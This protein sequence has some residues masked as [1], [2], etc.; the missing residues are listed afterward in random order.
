MSESFQVSWGMPVRV[1]TGA[2]LTS[3]AGPPARNDDPAPCD[4]GRGQLE[5]RLVGDLDAKFR[6][7]AE[8]EANLEPGPPELELD[9]PGAVKIEDA[10]AVEAPPKYSP[11][12][13]PI[14]ARTVA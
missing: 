13:A 8:Q 1:K 10:G 7:D 11:T 9:G 5:H 14:I 6:G 2:M 12:T 3:F 4:G